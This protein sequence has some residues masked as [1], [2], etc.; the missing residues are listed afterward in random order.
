MFILVLVIYYFNIDSGEERVKLVKRG[1]HK[2]RADVD[3][4]L[5]FEK[6]RLIEIYNKT[7][8]NSKEMAILKETFDKENS[9]LYVYVES[10]TEIAHYKWFLLDKEE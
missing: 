10:S 7:Y 8:K 6:S 5:E 9:L 1:V 3:I 2:T 4:K